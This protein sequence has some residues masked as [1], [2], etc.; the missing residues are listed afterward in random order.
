[1]ALNGLTRP[2]D[3]V[4]AVLEEPEPAAALRQLSRQV[5]QIVGEAIEL[6]DERLEE[7]VGEG[8]Q[9][10]RDEPERDADRGAPVQP[11]A[12]EELHQRLESHRQDDRHDQL[13]ED[14]VQRSRQ[15]DDGDRT[16][17]EQDEEDQGPRR[18]GDLGRRGRR[19][20]PAPPRRGD[21]AAVR[22]RRGARRGRWRRHARYSS[23]QA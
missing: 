9:R 12:L 8:D 7:E 17:D 22:R 20:P 3:D 4:V 15:R 2:L 13:H 19:A 18:Y 21:P 6:G 5:G 23:A 16:G 11:A 1:V 10:D 14:G